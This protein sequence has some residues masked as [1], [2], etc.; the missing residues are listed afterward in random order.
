MYKLM[1]VEDE[2]MIRRGIS[3]SI[4]WEDLGFEIC[5][6]A[7]NGKIAIERIPVLMP[8][9]VLTD[10]RMP[11]V[12]GLELSKWINKSFP[13]IKII[14]LSGFADFEYAKSAIK[15]RVYE[16]LLKPTNKIKFHETFVKLKQILDDESIEKEKKI[17]D[18]LKLKAGLLK[19]R[20]EFLNDL[21]KES[22]LELQTLTDRLNYLEIDFSASNYTV[23]II[24]INADLKK[25]KMEWENDY[26]ILREKYH[27]V[28]SEV[29]QDMNAGQ[30]AV[31]DLSE[32]IIILNIK[33]SDMADAYIRRILE[34]VIN[35]IRKLIFNDDELLIC[36]GVGLTYPNIAL[37][38]KSYKQAE[39]AVEYRFHEKSESVYFFNDIEN[40]EI[41]KERYWLKNYPSNI[42]EI[43]TQ[44]FTGQVEK[45]E[46]SINEIF[47]SF[48]TRKLNPGFIKKHTQFMVFLLS[49]NLIEVGASVKVENYIPWNYE[50][51][52]RNSISVDALKDFIIKIF[53]STAEAIEKVNSEDKISSRRA[54]E[55]VKM[56]IQ[57]NFNK[58]ISLEEL[59]GIVYLSP[60]YLSLLFKNVTG[61]NYSEYLKRIR[62]VKAKELLKE[63]EL[64]VYEVAYKVGFNEY[65]YFAVQFKKM[66]GVTPGELRDRE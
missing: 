58:N 20:N 29:L 25:Y 7:E 1:I 19:M 36:A 13:E 22:N 51:I 39:S 14:I 3:Q 21:I 40:D 62:M 50:Q 43:I 18:Q 49:A 28:V 61:E 38:S 31:N 8:D 55:K 47:Q 44:T 15:F 32:L 12:D 64:K 56:Y 45:L 59:A 63:T 4:D 6:E 60:S 34:K 23:A 5:F 27:S 9:V 37:L 46:K 35:N 48:K 2:E 26:S 52:I 53:I 10:V 24:K 17:N 57:E 33:E 65:K 16:Y 11:V 42:E 41:D 30:S 54:I 66:F